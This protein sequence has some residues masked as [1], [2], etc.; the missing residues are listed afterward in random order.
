MFQSEQ[1]KDVFLDFWAEVHVMFYI[2]DSLNKQR[3]SNLYLK[4]AREFLAF[5]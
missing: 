3:R 5:L 2:Y 4:L 1:I